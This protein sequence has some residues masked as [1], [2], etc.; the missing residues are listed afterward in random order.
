MTHSVPGQDELAVGPSESCPGSSPSADGASQEPQTGQSTADEKPSEEEAVD[1]VFQL[2]VKL[3][4]EPHQLH[5]ML[6]AQEQVQDLRQAIVE[7]PDAFQYSCFHLEHHGKRINDF[8]QLCDVPDFGP[9]SELTLVEDPYTEKDA[10]LHVIRV[11]ELLAVFG[12]RTDTVFGAMAGISLFNAAMDPA[13]DAPPLAVNGASEAHAAPTE[14][15]P[16]QGYDFDAPGSMSHLLPP[17]PMPAPRV[18]KALSLSPWNPP[19]YSFRQ[20]GHLLYL[21][22]TTLEGEQHQITA[23]V[24]GFFTNRCSNTKFDPLPRLPPRHA[25]AHSLLTLIAQLS[26]SF[27]A[28]FAALQEFNAQKDPLAAFPLTSAI[29]A[30]PWL[31]PAPDSPLCTHV[32]DL[33]RTQESFL[34]GGIENAETLRDWNEEFQSTREMP[35]DT[36]QARVFRERLTSKLFADY[37]EAAVRG[38]ILVARNEV[39]ALNPTEDADGQIFVYNNVFLSFGADGAGT[40]ASVGGHEAARVA[41][42]KD[43]AGVRAINQLDVDGLFTPGTVV[44]DYLGKRIVAQTIVPGIFKQREPGEHQIDYGGVEGRDVVATNAAFVAPFE[45]MSQGLKVK[46][47]AVWDKDGQR[48]DLEASVETKGLLGTDGRKYV[49]DL[50]RITPLDISWI[51]QHC[52]QGMPGAG[53]HHGHHGHHGATSSRPGYPHRMSVLR[54]ELIDAYY[55]S[56]LASFVTTELQRRRSTGDGTDG[57]TKKNGDTEGVAKTDGA[58]E[59]ALN[60]NGAQVGTPTTKG[61]QEGAPMADEGMTDVGVVDASVAESQDDR[62][63]LGQERVDLSGFQFALNPDAFTGQCPQTDEEKTEWAQDEQEVRAAGEYLLATVIPQLIRD[64]REGDVGFPMDGKALAGLLQRRGINVRYLGLIGQKVVDAGPRLH[65]LIEIAEREMISRAFKH[66]ANRH[67]QSL[68]PPFAASCLAHLLNCLLGADL[69]DRPDAEVDQTVKMLFAEAKIDYPEATPT[70]LRAEIAMQVS[71]RFRYELGD[72]WTSTIKHVPLLREIALKLGLQLGLRDYRFAKTDGAVTPLANGE[73]AAPLTNGHVLGNGKK[74]KKNGDHGAAS[75]PTNGEIRRATYTFV[76][77]DVINIVPVVKDAAPKSLLADETFEAGRQ[78]FGHG[79][80]EV[81]QELLLESLSLHEQIYG[82][83]HPEVARF[84]SQ[85]SM[86]YYQLDDKA[87]AVELARK[88]VVISERTVGVDSAETIL[89][90]LNLGLFEHA[91]G[92]THGALHVM[93]HALEMWKVIYGPHHPDAITTTNNV[94]VMLQ[95]LKHY[96]DSRAWFEASLRISDPIFGRHSLHTATLLF[97]LAQALALDHDSKPAVH[98]MRDAYTIFLNE[99]G[100]ADKNTK[101]AETWLEQLTQNAVSIAKHAKDMQAR[102]LRHVLFTPRLLLGSTTRPPLQMP[103]AVGQAAL[104]PAR[105]ALRP[106]VAVDGRASASGGGSG[107]GGRS[108]SGIAPHPSSSSSSS[109]KMARDSRSIDELIQ[110]IEGGKDAATRATRTTAGG[111]KRPGRTNPKRRGG[112]AAAAAAVA[113]V[114]T[115]SSV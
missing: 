32:S 93:R 110:F 74:K 59:P 78:S 51:E 7:V 111:K 113:P 52:D 107:S 54:P 69:N 10:R 61:A 36:M 48:H 45:K 16:M 4:H 37:N 53:P 91:T 50:Y 20:R 24:A 86:L 98:R 66:I 114:P 8:V 100:P 102:R 12:D 38:A 56:K 105:V 106:A 75:P 55:K 83:L 30:S 115:V 21:Q 26:P 11:R 87:T 15:H 90:Y 96:H 25:S 101:E 79:Q 41:T 62:M 67:L 28:A 82:I 95:S 89:C 17:D 104:S 2:P 71:L 19:P 27:A 40:F 73:S 44:V 3:P 34:I 63:E 92:H 97:Q 70:T 43:V 85:L 109:G 33:T 72:D 49:L 22:L 13:P 60:L 84:Y 88:A 68:P 6:S 29:P 9:R 112:M 58:Q 80:K 94:A 65:A 99:L 14:P 108:G 46:K 76:A 23:S 42:G 35:S 103:V 18:V 31:V 64:L 77:E 47:H 57:G 1:Y 81:G 39:P 5:I